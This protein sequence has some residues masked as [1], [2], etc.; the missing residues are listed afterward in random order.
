MIDHAFS[1]RLVVGGLTQ[2]GGILPRL[3]EKTLR[4][5]PKPKSQILNILV[6]GLGGG[7]VAEVV[8]KKWPE[9]KIVGVEIDPV[10][11]D[12]GKKYFSLDNIKNLEI[13]IADAITYVNNQLF[14]LIIVDLYKGY[15]VEKRI[16]NTAFLQ[17]LGQILAKNGVVIFNVISSQNNDFEAKNFLDKLHL[18]FK[19]IFWKRIIVNDIFFCAKA[20]NTKGGELSMAKKKK[21]KRR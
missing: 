14:D 2:S 13:I 8:S 1:R 9:A 11:I 3:W 18:I 12:I 16:K 20:I 21:K 10:M 7:T 5:I 4:Q 17:K 15:K 19:D 6:L